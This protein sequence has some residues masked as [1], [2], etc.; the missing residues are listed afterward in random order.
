M[1]DSIDDSADT[2]SL[3]DSFLAGN[4]A[5]KYIADPKKKRELSFFVVVVVASLN[6][7]KAG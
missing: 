2:K 5:G 6:H 3:D 7:N 1:D 4:L